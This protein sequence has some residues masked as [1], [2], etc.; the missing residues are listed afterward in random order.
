MSSLSWIVLPAAA[1]AVGFSLWVYHRREPRVAGASL[2]AGLR[3][4]AL[5]LILLLLWNPDVPAGDLPGGR[6]R[7]VLLD[8][9]LSMAVQDAEGAGGTAATPWSR[10]V[11]R[12]RALEG[13]GA[14][15][16]PFGG[17][18]L[19]PGIPE[20]PEGLHTRLTPAL[21]R[22]AE[23]GAREVTVISDLRLEDPAAA[24][25][26]RRLALELR[27][28]D[29]GGAV[30]NAG[31]A[32]LEL[33][34]TAARQDSLIAVVG[35]FG[36]VTG[37]EPARPD[38]ARL[39]IREE[40]MLRASVEVALPPPGQVA[41]VALRLPPPAAGGDRF[42]EARIH[43]P[44]DGFPD[45]DAR[46]RMVSVDSDEGGLV[47]VSLRP[48]LEPR[49]LLPLLRDISGLPAQGFLRA[50]AA[51]WVRMDPGADEDPSADEATVR[52]AAGGADLLVLHGVGA[53]VPTWVAEAAAAAPRSVVLPRDRDGAALA[54][55]TT[56]GLV[57][58]EWVVASE[59]PS[60]P[61]APELAGAPL[62]GLPP[63]GPLLPTG[64][65]AGGAAPLVARLQGRGQGEAVL[66]LLEPAGRRSV[67]VLAG[68]LWRWAFREGAPRE[69][70]RRLWSGA[71]GW[72]LAGRAVAAAAALRLE[73]PVVPRGASPAWRVGVEGVDPLRVVLESTEG[74]VVRDTVVA[75]VEGGRVVLDPVPPG[76]YRWAA[77]PA[78]IPVEDASADGGPPLGE[79]RVAVEAWVGELLSLPVD[80]EGELSA[81]EGVEGVERIRG[82][83]PLRTHPLPFLLLLAV[84]C[85]EWI[86]RRRRGLR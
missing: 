52:R 75:P 37:G 4:A 48:D 11:A 26:A 38:S 60:S 39:E 61:L 83:R 47:L 72:L 20:S 1:A 68:G 56:P 25:V 66:L 40:G 57:P 29:V 79:G 13:G 21:E 80:L 54:G 65:A 2:L 3:G 84:L 36:E 18:P 31:V 53:G 43:L 71:V 59:V 10:A 55:V 19:P 86:G 30:R 9:S 45:D 8:R 33:P 28:E 7:V 51:Q 17:D 85:G 27:V 12:A 35:F 16:I 34:L 22:A 58:G 81:A 49:F 74:G 63:L 76:L 6:P 15:V 41:S 23:L 42:Y 77:Y 67:V 82:G 50:G 5:V 32:S 62:A 24:M 44:G 64:G 46:L 70:Y 69:V 78:A 14:R 73:N